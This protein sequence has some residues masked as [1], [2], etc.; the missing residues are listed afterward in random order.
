MAEAL[1]QAGKKDFEFHL[2]RD[3]QHGYP[4]PQMDEMWSFTFD[5]LERVLGRTGS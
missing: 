2:I 1:K 5:F 3:G 4:A